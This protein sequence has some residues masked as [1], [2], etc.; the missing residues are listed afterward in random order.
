MTDYHVHAVYDPED[1][2]PLAVCG[3]HLVPGIFIPGPILLHRRCLAA[4]PDP[5]D[6]ELRPASAVRRRVLAADPDDRAG[7]VLALTRWHL[8]RQYDRRIRRAVALD[9]SHHG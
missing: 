2:Y 3:V 5:D 8:A 6:V 9:W 7:P 1:P 4:I